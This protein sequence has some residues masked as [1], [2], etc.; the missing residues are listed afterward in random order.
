[1][2]Y[3]NLFSEESA[4]GKW[5]PAAVHTSVILFAITRLWLPSNLLE[6]IFTSAH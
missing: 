6:A 5:T 1:M 2:G 3:W 4:G